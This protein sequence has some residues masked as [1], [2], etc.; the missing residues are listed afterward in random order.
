MPVAGGDTVNATDINGLEVVTFGSGTT[1]GAVASGF[2]INSVIAR[3]ALR[4]KLIYVK[5]DII[6]TAAITSTSGDIPDTTIFTLVSPLRPTELGNF[7]FSAGAPAGD[8][9][10][11]GDGTCVI[12]SA[13]VSI[14]AT[15]NIR[16]AFSY[17]A[18]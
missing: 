6:N 4:G 9:Q 3:T 1:C 18:A 2:S 13:N 14:P 11:N 12:R 15:S 17:L 10:I 16:A 8:I 7:H 5:L